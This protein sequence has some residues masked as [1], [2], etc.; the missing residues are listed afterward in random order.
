MECIIKCIS[1]IN[2]CI[3]CINIIK[4]LKYRKKLYYYD[5]SNPLLDI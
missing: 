2:T 3:A 5:K 4:Y 1:I